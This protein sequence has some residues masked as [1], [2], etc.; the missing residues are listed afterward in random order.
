[1]PSGNQLN[2]NDLN[3]EWYNPRQQFPPLD[4]SDFILPPNPTGWQEQSDQWGGSPE[5][6]ELPEPN[7]DYYD[8]EDTEQG[9]AFGDLDPGLLGNAASGAAGGALIALMLSLLLKSGPQ[10]ATTGILGPMLDQ[11][12]W[13]GGGGIPA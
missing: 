3:P 4:T 5:D 13:A 6:G 10:G 8:Q 2:M 1:M 7:F 11:G 12:P 9:L